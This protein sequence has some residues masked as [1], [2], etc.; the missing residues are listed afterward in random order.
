[1]T[2]FVY[3]GSD[4]RSGNRKVHCLSFAQYI[5][6]LGGVRGTQFGMNAFNGKLLIAEKCQVYN[7]HCF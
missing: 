4:Q 2:I 6:G 5:E 7:F 1:M 3:K